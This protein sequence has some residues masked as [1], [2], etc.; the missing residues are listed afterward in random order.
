LGEKSELSTTRN[1]CTQNDI[2]V[3]LQKITRKIDNYIIITTEEID[4]QV[5][6]YAS[7]LYTLTGGIEFAI[8]DCLGFIWHFLHLFHR[9][10]LQFLDAYQ[11][12]LLEEPD[13]AVRQSLKESFFSAALG[14]RNGL[15]F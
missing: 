14:C 12:L 2:D 13:S 7:S 6:K 8:L 11:R 3:A 1:G 4:E 9:I 5:K 10:R 15:Y